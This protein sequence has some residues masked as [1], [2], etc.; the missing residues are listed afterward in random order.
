M[1]SYNTEVFTI[2][3]R[4]VHALDLHGYYSGKFSPDKAQ[5]VGYTYVPLDSIDFNDYSFTL[6]SPGYSFTGVDLEKT[7][8][9]LDDHS[10]QMKTVEECVEQGI[11][12]AFSMRFQ[13]T[14]YEGGRT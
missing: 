6:T 11:Y 7:K 10:Y 4:R 1:L 9:Y 8:K 14:Y 2:L 13:G 3:E 5:F 12:K